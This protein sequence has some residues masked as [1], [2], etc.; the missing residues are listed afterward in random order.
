MV[1]KVMDKKSIVILNGC[2]RNLR[3]LLIRVDQ[4]MP[5]KVVEGHRGQV[6]QNRLFYGKK[7]KV[8]YPNSKHNTCPSDAADVYP[9]P[10]NWDDIKRM[11]YMGGIV[12]GV[13]E[14]MGI[15]IRW[16][17][18]WDR[19]TEVLDQTFNDLGHVELI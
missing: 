11:Y 9:D 14:E 6:R 13:A 2:S 4:I 18:D 16:G 8:K 3:L 1:G 19:D 7:T 5:I 15:D 12:R 17:G 10:V